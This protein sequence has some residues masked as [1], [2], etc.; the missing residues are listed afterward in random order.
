MAGEFVVELEDE[1]RI[2]S[3]YCCINEELC[4]DKSNAHRGDGELPKVDEILGH[5]PRR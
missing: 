2:F 1:E 4:N 5:L 3:A